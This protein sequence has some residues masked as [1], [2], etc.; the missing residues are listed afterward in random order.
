MNSC[1][2]IYDDFLNW[3]DDRAAAQKRKASK[4]NNHLPNDFD[5]I[6]ERDVTQTEYVNRCRDENWE[7][8]LFH[9]RGTLIRDVFSRRLTWAPLVVFIVVLSAFYFDPLKCPNKLSLKVCKP[10]TTT[11]TFDSGLQIEISGE[12]VPDSKDASALSMYDDD[13]LTLDDSTYTKSY[14]HYEENNGLYLQYMNTDYDAVKQVLDGG[15]SNLVFFFLVNIIGVGVRRFYQMYFDMCNLKNACM[16]FATMCKAYCHDKQTR[17]ALVRY[18]NLMVIS[19]FTG[20]SP[21]YS[22][23]TLFEPICKKFDLLTKEEKML[24]DTTFEKYQGVRYVPSNGGE[25][26]AYY[27]EESKK[28]NA[29]NKIEPIGTFKT[30]EEAASAY[31]EYARKNNFPMN[32]PPES[33][34]HDKAMKVKAPVL[35]EAYMW[36]LG[37]LKSA[38]KHHYVTP[39][40]KSDLHLQ[41]KNVRQAMSKLTVW[42]QQPL[43]FPF[44]HLMLIVSVSFLVLSSFFKAILGGTEGQVFLPLISVL[45]MTVAS[46]GLIKLA[47]VL[48]S[49]FRYQDHSFRILMLC[50]LVC[51][52]SMKAIGRSRRPTAA[53]NQFSSPASAGL[54]AGLPGLSNLQPRGS[55]GNIARQPD[56][57]SFRRVSSIAEEENGNESD[58]S[59]TG[60]DSESVRARDG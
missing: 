54:P 32:F 14:H 40:E 30:P 53:S 50:T 37:L 31:D 38:E 42:K 21:A 15:V 5:E 26:E 1:L 13:G 35:H 3:L 27:L 48:N 52:N 28:A 7:Q 36:T 22:R 9:W 44:I 18:A 47:L 12:I 16:K 58:S 34:D 19:G 24:I 23:A 17:H 25:W 29:S 46:F 6:L 39:Q 8:I 33:G 2:N 60:D 57:P 55:R 4:G 41:A 45:M 59:G 56:P 11:Y 51:E 43:L 10:N 20:L 49:P